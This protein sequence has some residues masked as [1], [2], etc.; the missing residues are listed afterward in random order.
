MKALKMMLFLIIFYRSAMDGYSK[1]EVLERFNMNEKNV[2]TQFLFL[3]PSPIILILSIIQDYK[4]KWSHDISCD[5]KA[6]LI[7]YL[8]ILRMISSLCVPNSYSA[9]L[10]VPKF[11]TINNFSKVN[12]LDPA[13]PGLKL[14]ASYPTSSSF[15]QTHPK[16][17]LFQDYLEL[18]THEKR[19][20]TRCT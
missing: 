2:I 12:L 14:L 8:K 6:K 13:D 3:N 7:L 10:S 16:Y 11:K 1:R 18:K 17:F 20:K 19:V 4:A 5:I 15:C 9:P